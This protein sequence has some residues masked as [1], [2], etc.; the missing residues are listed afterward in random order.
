MEMEMERAF[1]LDDGSPC[2]SMGSYGHAARYSSLPP[3]PLALPCPSKF[4]ARIAC[5]SDEPAAAGG[6]G[7]L[8]TP[9]ASPR[10]WHSCMHARCTGWHLSLPCFFLI[11][12]FSLGGHSVHQASRTATV[13]FGRGAVAN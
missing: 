8:C 12:S 6:R 13:Q 5:R 7:N 11:V 9:S 3:L 10:E 2:H 1:L 4:I